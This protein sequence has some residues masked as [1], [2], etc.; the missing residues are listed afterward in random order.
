MW[1]CLQLVYR[2]NNKIYF[3]H[4]HFKD[5]STLKFRFLKI[6]NDGGY[7]YVGILKKQFSFEGLTNVNEWFW[8]LDWFYALALTMRKQLL[9]ST[10]YSLVLSFP[11]QFATYFLKFVT[12]GFYRSKTLEQLKC[13]LEQIIGMSKRKGTS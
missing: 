10:T 3:L 9:K 2:Q 7:K 4:G 11:H 12:G 8:C 6:V 13:K 5:R 1:R